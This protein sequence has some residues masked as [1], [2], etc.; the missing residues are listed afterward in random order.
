MECRYLLTEDFQEGAQLNELIVIIPFSTSWEARGART[1]EPQKDR[2][3][4]R[5]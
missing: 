2:I 1:P 4:A 3:N 5:V